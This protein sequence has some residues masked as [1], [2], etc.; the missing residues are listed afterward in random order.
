MPHS[1]HEYNVPA[2]MLMLRDDFPVVTNT[3]STIMAKVDNEML[4][5]NTELLETGAWINIIGYVRKTVKV[6][7]PT[8]DLSGRRA[9]KTAIKL[10][11]VDVTLVWSAGAIQHDKYQAAV[12]SYR[13]T[14]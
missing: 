7:V 14:T 8:R 10:P 13:G 9:S 6:R 4:S 11:V 5:L 12:K 1:V 3:G 2:G